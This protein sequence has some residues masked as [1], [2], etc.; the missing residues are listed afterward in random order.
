MVTIPAS[1]L[2][3]SRFELLTQRTP[4]LSHIFV[5]FLGG[6]ILKYATALCCVI[7]K[8]NYSRKPVG[9][10]PL[11]RPGS[12]WEDIIEMGLKEG[13]EDFQWTQAT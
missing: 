9:N 7:S 6:G 12:K 5:V 4:L 2:E 1:Y 8:R 3:S 13:C 10:R 11:F